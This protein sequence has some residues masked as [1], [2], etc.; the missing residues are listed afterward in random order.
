MPEGDR[1]ATRRPEIFSLCLRSG[2]W[3]AF[4]ALEK[5]LL[6]AERPGPGGAETVNRA[7]GDFVRVRRL[8]LAG[9]EAPVVIGEAR[10]NLGYAGGANGWNSAFYSRRRLDGGLDSQPRHFT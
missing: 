6:E 10:E 7:P 8:C 9:F 1:S 5:A 3:S 2:S 4:E